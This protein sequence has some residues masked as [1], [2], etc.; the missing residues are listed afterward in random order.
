MSNYLRLFPEAVTLCLIGF[1]D[2]LRFTLDFFSAAVIFEEE[3][4]PLVSFA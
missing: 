4:L 1:E 3:P 2:V